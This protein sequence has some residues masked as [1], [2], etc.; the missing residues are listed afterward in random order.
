MGSDI[1][2][3]EE[4][5]PDI[6]DEDLGASIETGPELQGNGKEF[7]GNLKPATGLAPSVITLEVV[8]LLLLTE[9]LSI[10]LLALN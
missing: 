6:T 10:N 3:E 4:E 8:L 7:N 2:E 1:T 9:V 5:D